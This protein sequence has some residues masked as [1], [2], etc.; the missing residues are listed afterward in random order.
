MKGK[1]IK[2]VAVDADD[3]LWDCQGYFDKV[4]Q[5][6]YRLIAPYC[7]DPKRELFK[8]ESGNMADMG[9]G[10]KAFTISILE[11]AMRVGG[12]HLSIA[13]LN[14]LLMDCK[15]LLHLPATPLKGVAETLEVLQE[16][17][18]KLVCFTKGELQDQEN[19]L[20]RSG[21]LK[22]FDDVEI[23]SD[24]TQREFLALCE[25]QHIHPSELLMI[26][27]SLKSDIAPALAIGAWGIHIPFHV[28]WQLEHFDDID[29]ERLVKIE[30]FSDVL[31]YI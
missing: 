14:G 6:L 25:H 7:D 21:L 20:K 18:Y 28:T 17:P 16:R 30:H 1:E 22:Y 5:H 9:Y 11:T 10:C 2:V 23:T 8:T 29:H 3:T 27:N 26:G 4:E 24:K 19:K 13:E 12:S 31:R 15:S